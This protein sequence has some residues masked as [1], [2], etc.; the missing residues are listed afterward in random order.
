M[1]DVNKPEDLDDFMS[2]HNNYIAR[3]LCNESKNNELKLYFSLP[4]AACESNLLEVWKA[5]MPVLYRR[6]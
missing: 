5:T 4:Q 1:F 6:L 3:D 2:S